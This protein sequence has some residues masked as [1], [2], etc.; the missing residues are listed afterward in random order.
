MKKTNTIDKAEQE[1]LC[2]IYTTMNEG[3]RE[4]DPE[5]F[6][7]CRALYRKTH[8]FVA[9]SDGLMLTIERPKVETKF[10]CGEDDRGQGGEEPGTMAYARKMLADKKTETGF[11]RANVGKFDKYMIDCFGREAWRNAKDG[12]ANTAYSNIPAV[13]DYGG[14]FVNWDCITANDYYPP[15]RGH[16]VIRI[17]TDDDMRRM[18]HGYM[19]VRADFIKRVRAYWKRF[20]ASKIKTWTYWEN[21]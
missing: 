11:F 10:C 17:M 14:D 6:D 13:V 18:R 19:L 7:K 9:L 2:D 12:R 8:H 20:G 15:I 5:H 16:R 1:R 4:R 3:E 21:A